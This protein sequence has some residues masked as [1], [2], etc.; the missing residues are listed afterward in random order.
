MLEGGREKFL[1]FAHHKLVLDHITAELQKKVRD[2]CRCITPC[3]PDRIWR[4]N[5]NEVVLQWWTQGWGQHPFSPLS[6]LSNAMNPYRCKSSFFTEAK[7]SQ[8]P[9]GGRIK[10]RPASS[11]IPGGFTVSFPQQNAVYIRIDGS[12][13]SAERQQLCEKFQF[14][15]NSCV[16]V[17]SITAANMGL[18]LHSAD[19]VIFAELFWNPGVRHEVNATN[20]TRLDQC[21]QLCLYTLV[22]LPGW[23]LGGEILDCFCCVW[24][25][26]KW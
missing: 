3:R 4:Q 11:V 7:V 2:T 9:S 6:P 18:T 24:S 12:T 25:L 26:R 22:F 21:Q 13:P 1:V 20:Y 19:L 17:L 10:N 15:T 8:T 23:R 16:A 14:C 5:V